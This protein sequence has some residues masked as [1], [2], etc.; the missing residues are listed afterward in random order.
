LTWGAK[1]KQND[2]GKCV[3]CAKSP[4]AAGKMAYPIT[5]ILHAVDSGM[6]TWSN[7]TVI[8]DC[9]SYEEKENNDIAEGISA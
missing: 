1:I 7:G 8:F 9:T 3:T 6:P 5:Q 2:E 4:C